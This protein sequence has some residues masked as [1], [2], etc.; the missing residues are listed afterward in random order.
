[1]IIGDHRV[2]TLI[3]V[4]NNHEAARAAVRELKAVGFTDSQIKVEL[5]PEHVESTKPSHESDIATGV[6]AG[7][8]AGI[9]VGALLGLGVL[10]GVVG[11]GALGVFLSAT[12]A[13]STAGALVRMHSPHGDPHPRKGHF[14]P[15]HT[16]VTVKAG[17]RADIACSVLNR[18][19]RPERF[20]AQST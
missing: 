17:T 13:G 9:G 12:A 19:N 11:G 10:T 3:E 4:F 15:G 1:M 2:G 5:H 7:T 6:K 20:A 18:F 16:I 8:A 14:I